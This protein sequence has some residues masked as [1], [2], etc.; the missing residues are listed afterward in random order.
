MKKPTKTLIT[1]F[2][3]FLS[4][5]ISAQEGIHT[6]TALI[7]T[8]TNIQISYDYGG[9]QSFGINCTA[10]ICRFLNNVKRGDKVLFNLGPTDQ[11][12]R[13]NTVIE[14][15]RCKFIDLKC[16]RVNMATRGRRILPKQSYALWKQRLKVCKQKMDKA[17]EL[18]N[19]F[20]KDKDKKYDLSRRDNHYN[21]FGAMLREPASQDCAQAFLE[22]QE[23]AILEA[24][25]LYECGDPVYDSCSDLVYAI[26]NNEMMVQALDRCK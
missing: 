7:A 26:P 22:K 16:E 6:G 11:N 1:L 8:E 14:I 19:R 24:S 2:C 10:D 25:Q 15:R 12:M 17:L 18:D 9:M 21:R 5:S 3:I 13:G 20:I 23:D 4:S